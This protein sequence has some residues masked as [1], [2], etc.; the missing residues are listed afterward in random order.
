[1]KPE[2]PATVRL[3]RLVAAGLVLAL[4]AAAVL[5]LVGSARIDYGRA[6]AGLS[7]DKEI[8]FQARLPRVLLGLLVGGALAV[9]GVLF[10]AL[11]RDALADPYVLGVA[12]GASVGAVLAICFGW[13]RWAGFS[14][15]TVSAW[16][17]AAVVLLLVVGIASQGNRMSSFTLL[18]AGITLNSICAALLLLLHNLADFGQSFVVLRWLMGSLEPVGYRTLAWLAA[19]V[20]AAVLVAF[21]RAREWNLLAVGEEWA[22]ARGVSPARSLLVGF[23]TGSLITAAVTALAGPI[24]FVGLIVPHALRLRVGADHRLLVPA[25]F[26]AGGVFLALCDTVARVALAP[27]EIPVGVITALLGGPFF[28]WLLGSRRRSLWL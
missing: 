24:A 13:S 21:H 5:P 26:F 10:Q 17:G 2:R 23:L 22:M 15:I 25:A 18:L 7:P 11:V 19:V 4:V 12:G 16:V 27:A 28:I 3:G 6:F 1:M 9:A 14:A 20:G 8:L